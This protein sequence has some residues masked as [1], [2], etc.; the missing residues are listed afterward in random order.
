MVVDSRGHTLDA[1]FSV[2]GSGNTWE[3]VF[4]SRGAGRN[5]DYSQ[6]LEVVL[7]R[8]ARLEATLV[9]AI[10]VSR[11]TEHLSESAR[12]L[13][14]GPDRPVPGGT[15]GARRPRAE[16]CDRPGSRADTTSGGD[17]RRESNETDRTSATNSVRSRVAAL[18]RD[19]PHA[20][21]L[22]AEPRA[23]R[24]AAAQ[25]RLCR[26]KTQGTVQQAGT[27]D[28]SADVAYRP[29]RRGRRARG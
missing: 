29:V 11:E 28:T 16:A 26:E 3:V 8:L 5:P 18:R 10:L 23:P 2:T 22:T 24:T 19:A 20:R 12:R 4:E 7:G 6:A 9:D 25:V 21:S 27:R 13:D 17:E 15:H 1:S 14:V